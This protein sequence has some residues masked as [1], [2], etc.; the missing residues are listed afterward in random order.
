MQV[1]RRTWVGRRIVRE[2]L[3]GGS[4][5]VRSRK[6]DGQSR[7]HERV[8][9]SHLFAKQTW[10]ILKLCQAF[11]S[12]FSRFHEIFWIKTKK[13]FL[14]CRA[15]CDRNL[16]CDTNSLWWQWGPARTLI[17][18]KLNCVKAKTWPVKAKMTTTREG[19]CESSLAGHDQLRPT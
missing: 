12:V 3:F 10:G 7:L 15:F 19:Y 17:G 5:S 4:A 13:F 2:L 14:R 9:S 6:G 16:W 11:C 18:F 1:D 8:Q